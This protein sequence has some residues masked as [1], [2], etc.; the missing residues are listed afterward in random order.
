MGLQKL[1]HVNIVTTRLSEMVEWYQSVLGL[2]LG[3]RP[4]FPFAGAWLYTGDTATIH[5]IENTGAPKVGSEVS[6]KL[7]HFAFSASGMDQFEK[8]LRQNDQEFEKIAVPGTSL[9][10]FHVADPEGNHM[11]IDFDTAQE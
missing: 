4:D 3:P 9:I 7:E 5:L 11:H 10:Q 1:D 2:S 6:L 8:R